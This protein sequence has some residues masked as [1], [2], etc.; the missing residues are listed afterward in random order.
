MS[1]DTW[2]ADSDSH[3]KSKSYVR[4]KIFEK[5]R[6]GWLPDSIHPTD[7]TLRQSISAEWD[8]LPQEVMSPSVQHCQ[9]HTQSQTVPTLQSPSYRADS[10]P[11]PVLI[12]VPPTRLILSLTLITLHNVP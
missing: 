3:E 9:I 8:S 4:T 11:L 10:V 5:W 2:A 6:T 1:K 12:H 7:D